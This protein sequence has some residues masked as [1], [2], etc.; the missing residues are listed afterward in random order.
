MDRIGVEKEE[1]SMGEENFS[2]LVVEAREH[3]EKL[4]TELEDETTEQ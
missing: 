3:I 1:W 2:K 4:E